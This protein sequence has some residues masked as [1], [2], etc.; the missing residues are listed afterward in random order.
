MK[1]K[2]LQFA[3]SEGIDLIGFACILIAIVI[4]TDFKALKG[5]RLPDPPEEY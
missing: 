1:E 5:S 3:K 4:L 2:I